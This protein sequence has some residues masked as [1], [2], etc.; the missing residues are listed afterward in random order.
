MEDQYVKGR[1]DNLLFLESL[2]CAFPLLSLHLECPLRSSLDSEIPWMK[3]A[4]KSRVFLLIITSLS[5]ILVT[6]VEIVLCPDPRRSLLLYLCLSLAL[7]NFCLQQLL[8]SALLQWMALQPWDP[9]C[10]WI[11][12]SLRCST[13]PRAANNQWLAGE[14]IWESNYLTWGKAN[15]EMW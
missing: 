11:S 1:K 14:G 12:R 8:T 4:P 2:A 5:Q 9:I 15:C 10:W 7:V 3:Q 6:G 13:P